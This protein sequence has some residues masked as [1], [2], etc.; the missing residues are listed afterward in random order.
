VELLENR[1]LLTGQ[2]LGLAVPLTLTPDPAATTLVTESATL[3]PDNATTVAASADPA[4]NDAS[5]TGDVPAQSGTDPSGTLTDPSLAQGDPSQGATDS[6]AGASVQGSGTSDPIIGQPQNASVSA[7]L[8]PIQSVQGTVI[9]TGNPIT[10]QTVVATPVQTVAANSL[11]VV[12]ILQTNQQGGDSGS[13]TGGTNSGSGS[14][15]GTTTTGDQSTSDR[16]NQ[17]TGTAMTG[18]QET[19]TSPHMLHANTTNSTANVLTGVM[20]PEPA[21]SAPS[22]SGAGNAANDGS[23]PAANPGDSG[24]ATPP[25]STAAAPKLSEDSVPRLPST[26]AQITGAN[27]AL[28]IAG[29]L[30]ASAGRVDSIRPTDGREA[31]ESSN[32]RQEGPKGSFIVEEP[33]PPAVEADGPIALV[34]DASSGSRQLVD[35][36]VEGP[37]LVRTLPSAGAMLLATAAPFDLPALEKGVHGFFAQLEQMSEQIVAAQDRSGVG[38]WVVALATAGVAL[39][40]ARRKLRPAAGDPEAAEGGLDAT[41]NWLLTPD[42]G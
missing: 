19:G 17:N 5:S 15:A 18:D 38:T 20:G 33:A 26:L 3:A 37:A 8:D 36:P 30:D 24:P 4:T 40:L 31:A 27:L 34:Q 32:E 21:R 41:W 11:T 10:G 39:E 29:G 28:R 35:E 42:P 22:H 23:N 25:A 1:W 14:D 12:P 7:G 9:G 16:T 6:S 13:G 2:L